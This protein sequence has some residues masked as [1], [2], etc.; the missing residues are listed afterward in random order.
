MEFP[1]VSEDSANR[2]AVAAAQRL[3]GR[4]GLLDAIPGART[5]LV[6]CDGAFYRAAL[7]ADLAAAGE[8]GALAPGRTVRVPVR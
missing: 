4:I 1:G 6:V 5:L 2:A 3:A 8:P 7:A